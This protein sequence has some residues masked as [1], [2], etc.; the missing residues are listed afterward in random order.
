MK[1]AN[2]IIPSS[3]LLEAAG[4]A[5]GVRALARRLRVPT[6]QLTSWME[7]EAQT[8]HTVFLRVLDFVGARS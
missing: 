6:K 2:T 4:I 3:M 1:E 7:G 8:P 5:G